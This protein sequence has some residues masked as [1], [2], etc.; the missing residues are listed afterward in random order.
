MLEADALVVGCGVMGASAAWQLVRRGVRRLVMLERFTVGNTRGSSHGPCRIFRISYSDPQYVQM[1]LDA[2]PMWRLLEAESGKDLLITVGA[3]DFGGDFAAR[4]HALAA[5]GA[6]HE[7]VDGAEVVRRWPA[8]GMPPDEPVLFQPDGGVIMADA[9]VQACVDLAVAGGAE[10]RE[11]TRAVEISE[12]GGR[13]VVR[14][15]GGEIFAAPVAVVT[16]GPWAE[17]VFA[18]AGI[19]VDVTP[20]REPVTYFRHPGEMSLP[21]LLDWGEPVVGSLPDPGRGIKVTGHRVGPVGD[22]EEEAGP[23]PKTVEVLS[24]WVRR[25]HPR[26]DPVPYQT[27]T[28]FFTNTEDD[29]FIMERQGPIVVGS[30]CSGHGFKFAPLI[31]SRLADLALS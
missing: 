17:P 10:L 30:P 22:P 6:R 18:T 7:I 12:V 11:G 23:D 27:E 3:L 15:E 28:C 9:T 16:P 29:H 1:G 5:C 8:L 4:S 14:T 19:R 31:G 25:H 2:I 21:T 13:V 20:T 26:A 24:E